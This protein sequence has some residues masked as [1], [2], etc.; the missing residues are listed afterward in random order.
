MVRFLSVCVTGMTSLTD[1]LAG[2]ERERDQARQQARQLLARANV[3]DAEI[4][5]LRSGSQ[6]M[7]PLGE[8]NRAG[9]AG[10]PGVLWVRGV[11]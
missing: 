4:D 1:N 10:D 5:A 9:F 6:P 2:L 8:L 7:A 3:L 11:G